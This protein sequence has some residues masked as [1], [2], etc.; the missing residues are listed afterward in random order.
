MISIVIAA[1]ANYEYLYNPYTAKRDRTLKLNQS[2]NNLIADNFLG[3]FIGGTG[4]FTYLNV[5]QDLIV[6]GNT[7]LLNPLY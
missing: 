3:N 5:L 2:G 1:N 6:L 7:N 4:N